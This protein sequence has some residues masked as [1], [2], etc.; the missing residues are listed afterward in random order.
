MSHPVPALADHTYGVINDDNAFTS[1]VWN[2]LM[3]RCY[4]CKEPLKI[5][6]YVMK[7]TED[8]HVAELD[9]GETI[10]VAGPR[11]I[12]LYHARC[13]VPVSECQGR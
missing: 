11:T 8:P 1:G 9:D 6:L 10:G 13:V 12:N 2:L 3:A 4:H 5:G 7:I